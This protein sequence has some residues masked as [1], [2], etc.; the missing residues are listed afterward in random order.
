MANFV[1]VNRAPYPGTQSGVSESVRFSIRND[2]ERV[3]K[4]SINFYLGK[5][6]AFWQGGVLPEDDPAVDFVLRGISVQTVAEVTRSIEPGGELKMVKSGLTAQRGTYQFGGLQ[7]PANVD[8]PLM[9]EFTLALAEA[10]VTVNAQDFT[11]VV[12][13]LKSNGTGIH[14]KFYSDGVS[15]WIEVHHADSGVIAAPSPDYVATYDWDQSRSHNYKILWH[16]RMDLLKLY[17]ST[18]QEELTSDVLL[19]DGALSDFPGP[20][21]PTEEPPVQPMA[22]F[23]HGYADAESV[24]YWHNAYLFNLVSSPVLDGVFQGN[25]IGFLKSDEV[26]YYNAD[27]KPGDADHPWKQ[28]PDSLGTVEGSAIITTEPRLRMTRGAHPAVYGMYRDEPGIIN[29]TTMLDFKISARLKSRDLDSISIGA[30]AYISDGV[31][32]ARL[33]LLDTGSE[34]FVGLL[35]GSDPTW[36]GDYSAVPLNWISEYTYRMIYDPFGDVTVL[37]LVG[38]ENVYEDGVV[39]QPVAGLPNATLPGPGLGFL[40]N[41]AA[42]KAETEFRIGR[43]RYSIIAEAWFSTLVPISPWVEQ[44][45]PFSAGTADIVDDTLVLDDGMNGGPAYYA[46]PDTID[47]YCGSFLE[48]IA[49]VD[50]FTFEGRDNPVREITGVGASIDDGAYQLTLIFAYAGD[51]ADKIVFLATNDDYVQNLADIK[52]DKAEVQGTYAIVDWTQLKMYRIEKSV[53]GTVRVYIDDNETPAI[54][55][56][57]DFVPPTTATSSGQIR[58]GNLAGDSDR[59]ALSQW[60]TVKHGISQGYDVSGQVVMEQEE[61]LALFNHA[62]NSIAEASDSSP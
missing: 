11:G 46:Y 31:K 44:P 5:G 60:K 49:K 58:F 28:M 40:L 47:D 4:G 18:G 53:G 42:G 16:P 33:A 29:S 20:L 15:R 8:A 52:A 2:T 38:S 19:V 7:A 6:A 24:S 37:R 21:P 27:T 34:Q 56:S 55:M 50:S 1:I 45:V 59:L 51:T 41:P 14:V 25:H 3:L 39:S 61:A 9:A 10:D 54:E 23:G 36:I 32:E 22:Y 43:V 17:V 48:F 12:F 13:G 26:V 57:Q 62:I 30:E 35:N